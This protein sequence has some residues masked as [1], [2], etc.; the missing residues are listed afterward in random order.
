MRK[1]VI[2]LLAI[3]GLACGGSEPGGAPEKLHAAVSIPPHAWLVER[4]G[5]EAVEVATVLA[6]GDSPATH[7]PTDVQVSR[8]LSSR[9][10]FS[11]GVPFE[12]GPWFGALAQHVEVIALNEGVADRVLKDHSHGAPV[13]KRPGSVTSGFDPHTWLSPARLGI[14]AQTVTAA[15][16][17]LDPDR[18]TTYAANLDALEIELA[19]LDHWIHS[20]LAPYQ[21]RAFVVFHPSWGYFADDYGLN[22]IAIEIEGKEPSDAEITHLQLEAR[23]FGVSTIFVQPEIAGRA[24]R[25]VA[26]TIGARVEILDPLAADIPA[27]LRRTTEAIVGSFDG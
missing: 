1:S 9:V 2:L 26:D 22:Q 17:R 6:P 27:N 21:G 19:E 12:A 23:E 11:S 24:A 15:L 18:S 16:S 7:Q 20:S 4:I 10:Y 13:A 8:V 5:G 14:Q 3:L 25:A